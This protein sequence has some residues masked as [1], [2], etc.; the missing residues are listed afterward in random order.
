MAERATTSSNM[1]VLLAHLTVVV[2]LLAVLSHS[3]MGV[4]GEGRLGGVTSWQGVFTQVVEKSTISY[5]GS[6][7]Q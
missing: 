4:D 3:S 1:P 7:P 6:M 5:G 2:P